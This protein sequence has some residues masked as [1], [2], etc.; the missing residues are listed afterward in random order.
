[1]IQTT[2][3][4]LG[5]DQQVPQ[6]DV[7]LDDPRVRDRLATRLGVHGPLQIDRCERIKT[8]YRVGE[9][10]RALYR[11]SIDGASYKVAART[12]PRERS[13]REFA[14]AA[15]SV[16]EAGA[17]RAVT[18]DPEITTVFWTFPHDRKIAGL[19][20]LDD[21]E[22][23]SRLLR[24]ACVRSEIVG[25]APERAATARCFGPTDETIGYVKVYADDTGRHTSRIHDALRAI[26][27]DAPAPRLPRVLGY[28]SQ[29]RAL[30]VEALEGCTSDRLTGSA[31]R[32]SYWRLGAALAALHAIEPPHAPPHRRLDPDQLVRAVSLVKRAR[33]DVS[34]TASDLAHDLAAAW[35]P[36]REP[37]VCLHG[38]VNPRNWLVQPDRVAL[39]DLDQVAL[40]PAAADVGSVIATLRYRRCVG[41]L[42]ST[43]LVELTDAFAAG[44]AS[45][46]AWPAD[47]TVRWYTAA[48]VLVERAFRAINRVRPEGLLH[49][50]ALLMDA[51]DVLNAGIG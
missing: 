34:V 18:H 39:I 35:A 2:N 4:L 14:R 44:Y 6:R 29:D 30:A 46:R 11:V 41:E 51:R 15:G 9:S 7:L 27:P 5:F 24:R 16:Q 48:A 32:T 12:F 3:A 36:G 19:S 40:G 28:A 49:L 50:N 25:Y 13:A 45:V 26:S 38:D 33:P 37:P 21:P 8:K 47:A 42:T 22:R 31:R 1:M 10:L 23:L 17:I 43:G 20:V